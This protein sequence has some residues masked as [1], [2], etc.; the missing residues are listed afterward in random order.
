M[1]GGLS[2]RG[3]TVSSQAMELLAALP[4]PGNFAELES[5]LSV[6][7]ENFPDRLIRVVD[8]LTYVRLDNQAAPLIYAG[9]LREARDRF[10]RDYIA[11]VLKQHKGRM[12]DAARALGIQRTNL[13]RKVRQLAVERRGRSRMGAEEL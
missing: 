3:N 10:E 2:H 13:Y 7:V 9:T 5:L 1:R 6:L 12:G 8:V 11:A 4:W